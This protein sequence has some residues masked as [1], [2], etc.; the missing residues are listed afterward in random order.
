MLVLTRKKGERIYIGKD[1]I[2]TV[3]RILSGE[4]QLGFEAPKEIIINREE[5][6]NKILAEGINKRLENN[7]NQES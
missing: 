3:T 4:V 6:H 5:I 2:I 1:I 7:N